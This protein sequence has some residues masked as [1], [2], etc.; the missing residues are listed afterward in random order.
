M[1]ASIDVGIFYA[2]SHPHN[3]TYHFPVFVGSAV[4]PFAIANKHFS[5]NRNQTLNFSTIRR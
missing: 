1:P 5:N 2:I 3:S 4:T